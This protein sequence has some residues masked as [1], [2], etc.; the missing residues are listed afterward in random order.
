MNKALLL[1]ILLLLLTLLSLSLEKERKKYWKLNSWLFK[2]KATCWKLNVINCWFSQKY[3]FDLVAWY[4]A[5]LLSGLFKIRPNV[6]SPNVNAY[7]HFWKHTAAMFQVLLLNHLGWQYFPSQLRWNLQ[8]HLLWMGDLQFLQ[9][10]L[11]LPHLLLYQS[12]HQHIIL[13]DQRFR[14]VGKT[15]SMLGTPLHVG[16]CFQLDGQQT[17]LLCWQKILLLCCR[18]LWC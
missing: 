18:P 15:W 7:F 9:L 3:Y 6:L 16:G 17:H 11:T 12:I 8:C 1:L 4:K 5:E 2:D 13:H 10:W 14:S